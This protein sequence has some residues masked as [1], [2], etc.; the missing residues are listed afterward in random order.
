[1]SSCTCS[2]TN[3]RCRYCGG[4]GDVPERLVQALTA[5]RPQSSKV[6]L[7]LPAGARPELVEK[8]TPRPKTFRGIAAS[9]WGKAAR[10][11]EAEKAGQRF[12]KTVNAVEATE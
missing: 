2:G 3:A 7:T 8:P 12:Q 10:K 6:D 9:Q 5:V 4:T 11:T 1:M